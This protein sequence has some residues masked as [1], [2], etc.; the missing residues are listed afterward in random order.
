MDE[1]L[2]QDIAGST[3]RLMANRLRQ[4]YA[5]CRLTLASHTTASATQPDAPKPSLHLVA[6]RSDTGSAQRVIQADEA[7]F[8]TLFLQAYSAARE[9]RNHA[10]AR[11]T[12]HDRQL[13]SA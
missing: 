10:Q 5:N 12:S 4:R 1:Y 8:A 13:V 11:A 7:R 2:K 6:A 3:Q 9:S